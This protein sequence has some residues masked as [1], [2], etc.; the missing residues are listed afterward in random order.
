MLSSGNEREVGN[1]WVFSL[2]WQAIAFIRKRYTD[3]L[4]RL[5]KTVGVFEAEQSDDGWYSIVD[6][7]GDSY[8]CYVSEA[9]EIDREA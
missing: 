1:I 4:A 7:D 9:V 2:R 6:K 3:E 5:G 8:E